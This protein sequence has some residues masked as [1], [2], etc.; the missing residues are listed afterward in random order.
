MPYAIHWEPPS[1]V[2]LEAFG[3][4]N[5]AELQEAVHAVH[6]SA[7]Y[8]DLRYVIDDL[9]GVEN[10]DADIETIEYVFA[11]SVGAGMGNPNRRIYVVA[12]N[13]VVRHHLARLIAAYDDALPIT[14]H[15]TIVEA[16][17]AKDANIQTSPSKLY[18]LP[19][20]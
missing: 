11:A 4:F 12:T 6:A 1:G 15:E 20:M 13:A 17:D 7:H 16:R 3:N 2:V 14:I 10:F 9:S 5:S 18:R 8:D 19:G